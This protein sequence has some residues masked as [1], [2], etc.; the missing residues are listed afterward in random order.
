MATLSRARL[1]PLIPVRDMSRAIKFYQKALGAKLLYRGRGQM[2][3]FWAGLRVA[4]SEVWFV[5]PGKREKRTL[6][7][8]TFLVKN[9]KSAVKGLRG[10][11]VKFQRP[12]RMSSTIRIEGPIG[13]EPFGG[14]AFFKDSE[15]NLLMVWQNIPPM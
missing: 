9:I 1:V 14:S 2:R 6:A 12:E 10:K 7:Y 11:G 4:G 5:A 13:W 8:H 15:G 3:N